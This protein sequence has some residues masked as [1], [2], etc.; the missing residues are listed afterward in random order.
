MAAAQH[1]IADNASFIDYI[2]DSPAAG[3]TELADSLPHVIAHR[4]DR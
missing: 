2:I 1:I 3:L 4:F